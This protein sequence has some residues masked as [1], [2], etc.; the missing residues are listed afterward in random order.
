MMQMMKN[1]IV[2]D[3]TIYAIA[4]N[5]VYKIVGQNMHGEDISEQKKMEDLIL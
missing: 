3:V 1:L 4:I 2:E 5:G